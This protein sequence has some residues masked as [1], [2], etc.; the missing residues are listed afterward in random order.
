MCLFEYTVISADYKLD[1]AGELV[2]PENKNS[3]FQK[4]WWH[5]SPGY[6]SALSVID[7]ARHGLPCAL[8]LV[9]II[10]VGIFSSG[11]HS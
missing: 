3:W 5:E 11:R 9:A 10:I 7:D 6:Q 4:P 1:Q 2:H 8:W